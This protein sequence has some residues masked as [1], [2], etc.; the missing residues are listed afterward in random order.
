VVDE[1]RL[2]GDNMTG[3]EVVR[4]IVEQEE[5]R[6]RDSRRYR[7]LRENSGLFGLTKYNQ[8]LDEE[9][10]RLMSLAEFEAS[11]GDDHES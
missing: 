9:V 7:F 2:L 1:A 11:R 4:H 8:Q 3:K 6:I 5:A 10:D